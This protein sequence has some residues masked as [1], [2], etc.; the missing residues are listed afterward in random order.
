MFRST[1]DRRNLI[2]LAIVVV[3]YSSATVHA[4][5]SWWFEI[6]AFTNF[7]ATPGIIP[8]L[9]DTTIWYKAVGATM[10]ALN[11]L[12]ADCLFVRFFDTACAAPTEFASRSGGVGSSGSE[13]C[14]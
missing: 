7:G 11:I 5:L 1:L 12:I 6:T 2:W 4:A 3:M 9:A 14:S 10:F 13:A 8:A